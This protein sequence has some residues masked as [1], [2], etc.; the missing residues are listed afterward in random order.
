MGSC[1]PGSPSGQLVLLGIFLA[2]NL[3]PPQSLLIP[4]YRM[5]PRGAPAFFVL[6]Q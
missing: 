6:G 2:A 5:F 1:S 3:L 4:V